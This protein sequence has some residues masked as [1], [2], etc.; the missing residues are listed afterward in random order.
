MTHIY[1]YIGIWG[2][3]MIFWLRHRQ[4]VINNLQMHEQCTTNI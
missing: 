3:F 2:V 1:I 4:I